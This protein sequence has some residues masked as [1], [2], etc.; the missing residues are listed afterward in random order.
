LIA[1]LEQDAAAVVRYQDSA[2]GLWYQVS[3]NPWQSGNY[4]E[5]SASCMFVYALHGVR[6]GYLP[7]LS[8]HAERGYKGILESFCRDWDGDEVSLTER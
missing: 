4:L 5:S 1:E 3:T 7:I 8:H 2:T 6:Q